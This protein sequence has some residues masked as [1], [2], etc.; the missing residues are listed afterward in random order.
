[1]GTPCFIAKEIGDNQYR[2]IYCNFDGY[3]EHVGVKL[4]RHYNTEE[5]V[6][7]LLDLGDIS[8]LYEQIAPDPDTPHNEFHQQKGVTLAYGRDCGENDFPATIKTLDELDNDE[9]WTETTYIF[10]KDKEWKYFHIGHLVEGLHE[11]TPI[12]EQIEAQQE[13][14]DQSE[15]LGDEEVEETMRIG[16]T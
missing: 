15:D 16:L 14:E 7:Q 4:A 2:T 6:D 9:L 5:M 11:L 12:V 1:M 10:T 8:C 3:L 13:Q